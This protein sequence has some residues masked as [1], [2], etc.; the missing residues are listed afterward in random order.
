MIP[1]EG[2]VEKGAFLRAYRRYWRI[3]GACSCKGAVI[4]Y[5]FVDITTSRPFIMLVMDPFGRL[6][7]RIVIL[8]QLCIPLEFVTKDYI[9]ASQG[10]NKC[11]NEVISNVRSVMSRVNNCHWCHPWSYFPYLLPFPISPLQ[12]SQP[13]LM[14][15]PSGSGKL[16]PTSDHRMGKRIVST[17]IFRLNPSQISLEGLCY[18]ML[19]LFNHFFNFKMY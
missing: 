11:T 5:R 6:M 10:R 19:Q 9:A 17:L 1:P 8:F 13:Q 12:A 4:N 3:Y 7:Q 2:P 16:V 15:F 18:S 14:S